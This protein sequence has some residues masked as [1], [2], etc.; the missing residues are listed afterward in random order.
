VQNE[1]HGIKIFNKL[2]SFDEATKA[3]ADFVIVEPGS[4]SLFLESSLLY[5]DDSDESEET[6]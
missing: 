4:G 3:S 6:K 2:K 5:A 1:S